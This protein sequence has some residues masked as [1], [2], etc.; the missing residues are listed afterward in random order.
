MQ[1]YQKMKNTL[2]LVNEKK[3]KSKIKLMKNIE[4]YQNSLKGDT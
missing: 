2:K 1:Y 3:D 4:K